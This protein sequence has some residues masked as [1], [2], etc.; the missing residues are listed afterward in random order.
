MEYGDYDLLTCFSGVSNTHL[1]HGIEI[2][3][4]DSQLHIIFL[5][6]LSGEFSMWL[7]DECAGLRIT[8]RHS[9]NFRERERTDFMGIGQVWRS[10]V[11]Y[12]MYLTRKNQSSRQ[13][14]VVL[15]RW[16]AKRRAAAALG[17][18]VLHC[19]ATSSSLLH[20]LASHA[21]LPTGCF[22]PTHSQHVVKALT[23]PTSFW[24][25]LFLTER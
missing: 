14:Y 7:C 19:P 23:L 12:S 1:M 3:A 13:P 2:L 24:F 5:Q 10:K 21:V 22:C 20:V 18:Q 25:F 16:R 4:I 8:L 15:L 17:W 6:A 11:S 9:F